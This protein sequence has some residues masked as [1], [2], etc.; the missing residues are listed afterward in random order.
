MEY[1]SGSRVFDDWIVVR[2]IG[3]GAGGVVYEIQKTGHDVTLTSALKVI[4]VP[5]D[6]GAA[7]ALRGDGMD[8]RSVTAYF[9]DVVDGLIEEIKIMVSMKG[10]PYVVSC[11]DYK[12]VKTS[13]Q[14]QWD[15]MIRME[16]LTPLQTYMQEH[17]LTE[18]DVHRMAVQLTKALALFE[19]KGIVHRDIK[20]G[21]IFVN[22]FGDFKVGDFGIARACD[23]TVGE[24]SKKGTEN[25]M[26]PEVYHGRGYDAT[27]DIYSLGLVLYKALNGNRL[28]F[29][30]PRAYT[31][32][33][34]QQALADRLA[35]EKPLPA[36]SMAGGPLGAVVLKMCAFRPEERYQ[37]AEELLRALEGVRPSDAV[38][39]PRAE[40]AAE[41]AGERTSSGGDDVTMPAVPEATAPA[42]KAVTPP[43]A[44]GKTPAPLAPKPQPEKKAPAKADYMSDAAWDGGKKAGDPKKTRF[45]KLI[46]LAAVLAGLAA[47]VVLVF[48][49]KKYTL[50][51]NGGSGSGEYKAGTQVTVTAEEQRGSSFAAWEA[52]GLELTDQQRTADTVT[53]AM[54]RGAASLTATYSRDT[55]A[56]TVNGGSGSGAYELDAVVSVE[57]DT[58]ETGYAFSGWQIN[59]GSPSLSDRTA[60]RTSFTMGQEQ[61]EL[62]AVYEPLA[63][64]L[65]VSGASGGGDYLYGDE[66]TLEAEAVEANTFTGW[67]VVRGDPGLTGE[68]LAEGKITF[69]MPAEDVELEAVY[70]LNRHTVTVA[71]GTGSGTFSV[72]DTVEITADAPAEGMAFAG[73]DT[74][75]NGVYLQDSAALTTTFT[76][77]DQD[78]TVTAGYEP[79]AYTVTVNNGTGSDTYHMGDMVTISADPMR[80]GMVFSNWTVDKGTLT[81]SDMTV[82][83]ISFTMPAEDVTVT[84][85]YM[86][87]KYTLTVVNGRGSGMYSPGTEVEVTADA[88]NAQGM[89]FAGWTVAA[90]SPDM[91]NVDLTQPAIRFVMPEGNVSIAASYAAPSAVASGYALTVNGGTGG[92]TFAAGEQVSVTH[93]APQP[94]MAFAYWF[95]SGVTEKLDLTADTLSFAMPANDVNVTAVFSQQ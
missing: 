62:T 2:R 58:P 90:G 61:V 57:A 34:Q 32:A 48:L 59:A 26:A 87:Q 75:K 3:A 1:Q 46:W 71:G 63:Y 10:F 51:V 78:V 38:V 13:E 93:D 45:K 47:V 36:P 37:T 41:D 70:A 44:A 7:A 49:S 89:A 65:T 21:N 82:L 76:M 80:E 72:G 35:G 52:E 29:Y 92:G 86:I 16:L 73:W 19:S 27:V 17:A 79:V 43:P 84:A 67:T 56:V 20:P 50:T 60:P 6:P 5:Q 14:A 91:T 66:V 25:Y 55:Y 53:V 30:P 69:T 39:L 18:S 94:G 68:Q 88:A 4:T 12:V 24:L 42:V 9:Q 23:R 81:L 64:T 15:V 11:E 83:N 85:H 54:P 77:P 22:A 74:G 33:D 40:A 31:A 28:P 95:V 8:E